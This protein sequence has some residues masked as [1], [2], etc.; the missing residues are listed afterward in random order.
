MPVSFCRIILAIARQLTDPCQPLFERD[1]NNEKTDKHEWQ[2]RQQSPETIFWLSDAA[3]ALRQ[4]S[5]NDIADQATR[6]W[7]T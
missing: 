2:D 4:S 5:H 1:S 6:L 7:A 3:I